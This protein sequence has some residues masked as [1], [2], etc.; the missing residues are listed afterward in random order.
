MR[1]YSVLDFVITYKVL[2]LTKIETQMAER[3]FTT[4]HL[5]KGIPRTG[6]PAGIAKTTAGCTS[7][8]LTTS[9]YQKMEE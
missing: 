5:R 9:G 4:H 7:G 6:H 8:L 1:S 2:G 3:G